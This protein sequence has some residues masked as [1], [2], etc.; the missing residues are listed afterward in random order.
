M[1]ESIKCHVESGEY[2]IPKESVAQ[3]KNI[4]S[5]HEKQKALIDYKISAEMKA[6][7]N[8]LLEWVIS[9]FIGGFIFVIIYLLFSILA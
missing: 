4:L 1:S 9:A 2:I 6:S 3:Y 8:N 5:D 7:D